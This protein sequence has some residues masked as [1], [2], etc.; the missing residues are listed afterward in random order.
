MRSMSFRELGMVVEILSGPH[1]LCMQGEVEVD[2]KKE[3]GV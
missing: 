3:E 1:V 2:F